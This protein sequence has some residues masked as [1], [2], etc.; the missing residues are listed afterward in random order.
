[1][2]AGRNVPLRKYYQA[3]TKHTFEE[4]G[5]G[6]VKVTDAEGRTG[7]FHWGGRWIEGE[8]TQANQQ[9]VLWCGGPTLP[10]EMN[11]RWVEAPLHRGTKENPWPWPEQNAP[12]KAGPTR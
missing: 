7:L 11:F 12:A 4:V 6:T 5:D 9:M 2:T 1:M 8:L 3:A 10:P